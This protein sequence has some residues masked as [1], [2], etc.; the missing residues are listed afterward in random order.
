LTFRGERLSARCGIAG[1]ERTYCSKPLGKGQAIIACEGKHLTRT[2]GQS[3]YCDHDQQNKN[4][5]DEACRTTNAL[6]GILKDVYERVASGVTERFSDVADAECITTDVKR[7]YGIGTRRETYVI[8]RRKVNG[9]LNK[10]ETLSV[11]KEN[12]QR[13]VLQN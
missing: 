13:S 9:M 6:R 2:G 1:E 3:T 10:K 7:T 4:D 8:N 5:T 12:S 11:A